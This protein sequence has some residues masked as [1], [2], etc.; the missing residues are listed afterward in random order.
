MLMDIMQQFHL[1]AQMRT[2][3]LKEAGNAASVG[4]GVEIDA[5]RYLVGGMPGRWSPTVAAKLATDV[6]IA[7]LS[8]GTR[9]VQHFGHPFAIG[10]WV[11]RRRLT[12]LATEQLVDRH[13]CKF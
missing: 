11:D 7:L 8:I 2:E 3:M 6:V 13:T 1:V 5:G 9:F 10:M 4:I 12:T